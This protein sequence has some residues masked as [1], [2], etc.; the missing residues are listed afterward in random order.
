MP[1]PRLP[2]GGQVPGLIKR[3]ARSQQA[4]V[5]AARLSLL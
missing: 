1:I 4:A 3:V 2:V 5:Q